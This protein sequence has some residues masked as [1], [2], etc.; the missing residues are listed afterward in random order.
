MVALVIVLIP[1]GMSL[2]C[3]ARTAA[4][5]LLYFAWDSC[6]GR[7]T[8][9]RTDRQRRLGPPLRRP[10]KRSQTYRLGGAACLPYAFTHARPY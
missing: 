3:I 7:L 5:I 8:E 9:E 10:S 1:M 6:Q 4:C 2:H